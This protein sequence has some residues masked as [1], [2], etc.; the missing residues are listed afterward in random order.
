VDDIAIPELAFSDGADS[1]GGWEAEGF[2]RIEKPLAQRFVVQ[3]IEGGDS[4]TVRR[5]ELDRENRIEVALD[6]PAIIVIA[7]VTDGTTEPAGYRWT[8]AAR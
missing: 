5:L 7:A 1:G 2:L 4:S 8:L 3:L 6:G